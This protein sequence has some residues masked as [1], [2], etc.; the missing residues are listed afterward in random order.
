MEIRETYAPRRKSRI[1]L[2]SLII[3]GGSVLAIGGIVSAAHAFADKYFSGGSLLSVT[4][5][6][7]SGSCAEELHAESTY[8]RA[9]IKAGKPKT[10]ELTKRAEDLEKAEKIARAN[11]VPCTRPIGSRK[12]SLTPS[13]DVE[14][15]I[16]DRDCVENLSGIRVP[17]DDDPKIEQQNELNRLYFD[18]TISLSEKFSVSC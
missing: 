8:V 16:R 10:I 6:K 13:F 18:L 4:D 3:A 11:N 17:Y 7:L 9:Q 14:Q 12:Y 15:L 1:L 5:L 2:G